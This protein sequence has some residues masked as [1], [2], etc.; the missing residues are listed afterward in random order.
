MSE[1]SL[2]A[3]L[4]LLLV[5]SLTLGPIGFF[6]A[7][8]LRGNLQRAAQRIAA[9]EAQVGDAARA[10]PPIVPQPPAAPEPEPRG[11]ERGFT[12]PPVPEAPAEVPPPVPPPP[13]ISVPPPDAPP[14]VS[15]P[16]VAAATP[17]VEPIIAAP[18]RSL[19][20][21][22]GTRWTIWVGGVALALGGLLLVSY[23][24]EQGWFGPAA[25]I[26]A[27][28]V[29]AA[30]LVTAGEFLR[31]RELQQCRRR[32]GKTDAGNTHRSRHGRGLWDGLCGARAL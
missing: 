14:R 11:D 19:E 16:Q 13:P 32:A 4:G 2:F 26:I 31:R 28:L 10:S 8:S 7:L 20:E 15:V 21:V 1:T 12:Q 27:G 22:L 5:G 30:A 29:F 17:S 9:L 3:L 6:I 23:S 25:R 18:R 24:I